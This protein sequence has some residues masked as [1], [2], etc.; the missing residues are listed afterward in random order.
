MSAITSGILERPDASIYFE[1]TGSGPALVFAHGL[2]GNHM[3]WWQQ[4]PFFAGRY[5]CVTFAH[6]G[7]AP[8]LTDNPDPAEFTGDLAALLKHLGVERAA[9]VA[10]SMGG[11]TCLDFAMYYPRRVSALVMAATS[12][13]VDPATLAAS[14]GRKI[15]EWMAAN[16]GVEADLFG[17]GI[18]P[19]AGERM[20]REQPA[21][22]FLYRE[23]DRMSGGLDKN[24][25]RGKL[26][27]A[28]TLPAS[29]LRELKMP[30][31]FVTG[32]EDIVIPPPLVEAL[33]A[34]VPGAKL[35]IVPE[36]G[37][38]VYFERAQRFNRAVDEF[39]SK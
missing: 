29:M 12:G 20:A 3:S 2:G 28:R 26:M 35:E 16:S 32:T 19:A 15:Q 1:V 21:L 27:A 7:F 6:R 5:T 25:L 17:R 36:A 30:V 22:A 11:W 8:S 24:A 23:I 10:Q 33:S 4:V 39:L 9:L 18:H 14:D 38:S 34:M 37:H 31:L 13:V